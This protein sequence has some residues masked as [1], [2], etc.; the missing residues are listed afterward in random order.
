MLRN[1][2]MNNV[3]SRVVLFALLAVTF[4]GLPSDLSRVEP[5]PTWGLESIFDDGPLLQDRN[6]DGFL[7]FVD[8]HIVLGAHPSD[9]DLPVVP[10]ESP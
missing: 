10:M 1:A 2:R 8:G 3:P 9:V 7:D 4:P 5:E 6:G